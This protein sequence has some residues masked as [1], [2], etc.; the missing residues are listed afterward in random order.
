MLP[1]MTSIYVPLLGLHMLMGL[2]SP[3]LLSLRVTV[4][5]RGRPDGGGRSRRAAVGVDGVLLLTGLALAFT[6]GR[7]PFADSWL[8]AKVVGLVVYVVAGRVA[9]EG[10]RM[11]RTRVVAWLLALASLLYAYGVSFAREPTL[12]LFS[13]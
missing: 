10:A 4:A 3:V 5:A 6:I 8:T 13:G 2:V 1:A 12:G 7:W 9:A 11:L